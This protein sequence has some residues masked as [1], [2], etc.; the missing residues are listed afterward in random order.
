MRLVKKAMILIDLVL[1]VKECRQNLKFKKVYMF[2]SQIRNRDRPR[3][4]VPVPGDKVHCLHPSLACFHQERIAQLNRM[5][6][7]IQ[8]VLRNKQTCLQKSLDNLF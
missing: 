6:V 5:H 1:S 7:Y 3:S 8:K 4:L 2:N